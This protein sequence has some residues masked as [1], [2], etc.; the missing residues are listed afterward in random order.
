MSTIHKTAIARAGSYHYNSPKQMN[1][2]G[3]FYCPK[4]D[5]SET[6]PASVKLSKVYNIRIFYTIVLKLHICCIKFF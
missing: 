1:A 3:F 6:K 2:L 4:H 5:H